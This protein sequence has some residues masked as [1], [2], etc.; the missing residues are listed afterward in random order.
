MS[1]IQKILDLFKLKEESELL[2]DYLSASDVEYIAK[3]HYLSLGQIESI[4][5]ITKVEELKP[6]L[7][8]YMSKPDVD[9]LSKVL[10]PKNLADS[11]TRKNIKPIDVVKATCLGDIIGYK[12]ELVEHDYVAAK[13]EV[14]PPI[15]SFYTDDTE[16]SIATMKAILKND[17]NPDFRREY[18]AAYHANPNAGYGGSFAVWAA[19]KL[20]V[21]YH[22]MANGS[23]MRISFI[24]AYYEDI[25]DVV[26][27]TIDSAMVT[28]NHVEGVRGAV[29]ISVCIWLALH[30]YS[31]EEIYEYCKKYY[32]YSERDKELIVYGNEIFDIDTDLST[33]GEKPNTSLFCC[34]SVPYAIKCFLDTN[35]YEECMREVLSRFGDTDTICA[36]AGGLCYAYYGET[37]FDLD[38]LMNKY[39]VYFD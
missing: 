27:H 4:L 36:I 31:K 20:D 11:K 10:T 17:K 30:N 14:L 15:S 24:P 35:S 28:H 25:N 1:L 26:K 9:F 29:I 22:S 3:L 39:H 16:L 12:Y 21:G 33:L 18:I 13:T 7:N 23:A 38:K 5:D 8:Y 2:E 32:H 34:H 19:R 6:K 37:G